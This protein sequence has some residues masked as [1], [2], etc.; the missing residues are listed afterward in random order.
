M[1]KFLYSALVL[2]AAAF[3]GCSEA[4]NGASA[5]DTKPVVTVYEIATSA[6]ADPDTTIALRLAPNSVTSEYYVHAI[7][8]AD[9]EAYVAAN[10]EAAFMQYVVDNGTCY[11]EQRQD[12]EL[13]GLAGKYVV[14]VVAVA[15]NGDMQLF[16]TPYEGILWLDYAQGTYQSNILYNFISGVPYTGSIKMQRAEGT[17]VYRLVNPYLTILAPVI[18]ILEG[19]NFGFSFSNRAHFIFA[20]EEGATE[21]VPQVTKNG[22]GYYPIPCGITHPSYGPM[23]FTVD[24]DPTY[25]LFVSDLTGQGNPGFVLNGQLKVSAGY[26]VNWTN[27]YY[28]ITKMY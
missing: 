24:A 6:N 28:I 22:D 12:I 27:D 13:S 7:K 9:K 25:S 14:A 16:E 3:V 2:L 1:K 26:F 21:I 15:E 18:S 4:D 17:N 5:G 23:T 8:L 20:W 10:G 11:A 19:P